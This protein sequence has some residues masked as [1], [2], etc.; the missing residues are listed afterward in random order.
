MN[1]RIKEQT[2]IHYNGEMVKKYYIQ[3]KLFP[4]LWIDNRSGARKPRLLFDSLKEAKYYIDKQIKTT[5][6]KIIQY[7]VDILRNKKENS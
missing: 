3:F 2:I 1:Y 4:F 7:D 6:Y 5:K